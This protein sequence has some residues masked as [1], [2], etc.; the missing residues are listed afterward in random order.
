[1]IAQSHIS[2]SYNTCTFS[3]FDLCSCDSI[4]CCAGL[5]KDIEGSHYE[6]SIPIETAMDPKREVL[7]AFQMNGTDLPLDHGYPLRVV[8]PGT[9]G[10]RQVKWL[11]KI[12]A[13]QNESNSHWQQKDYKTFAPSVDWGTANFEK[14]VAIQDYPLQSGV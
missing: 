10:A 5:D 2:V 11:N 8:V 12:T 3:C 9:V 6:A 4:A 7:L 13:S 1:M 14:A